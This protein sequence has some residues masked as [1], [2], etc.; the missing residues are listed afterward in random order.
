MRLTLRVVGV[1]FLVL[2]LLNLLAL[3]L[4]GDTL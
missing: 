1:L 3:A 2:M 4:T